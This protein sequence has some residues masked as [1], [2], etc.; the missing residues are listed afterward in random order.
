M[1]NKNDHCNSKERIIWQKCCQ[2]KLVVSSTHKKEKKE[3]IKF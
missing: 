2:V 1:K 3:C